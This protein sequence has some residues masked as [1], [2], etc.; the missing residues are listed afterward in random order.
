[1]VEGAGALVGRRLEWDALHD[2]LEGLE[3]KGRVVIE[4]AG[5]QGIGKTRLIT[6]LCAEAERR[7]YLVFSGRAAEFEQG[8][9]FGVFVDALDDYLASVDRTEFDDLGVELDELA[10]V[11]PAL[12]RPT[13]HPPGAVSVE[14]YRAH[15]EMRT[16]LDA[17]SQ[18][19]PVVLTL[20]DLHWADDASIELVSYLLR[21]PPRG[22]VLTVMAFRPAQLAKQFE[23]VLE[24]STRAPSVV[25]LDLHPLTEDEAS[26]L[27]DPDLPAPVRGE[28][29][30]LSGGNPFYLEELVRGVRRGRTDTSA[31]SVGENLA[32]VPPAV[33]RALADELG[34]LSAAAGALIR[35][36]AVVGDPFEVGLAAAAGET[37]DS[38]VFAA[39]DELLAAHLVRPT[40]LPRR[41]QFR[42]PLVRHAVYQTAP[43][44]WR[45]GAHAR[46]A[47]TLD[48]QGA[49]PPARAHHVERS[50]RRG[51]ASAVGLLIEAGDATAARAPAIAARWY[52]AALRL[53]PEAPAER[54]RR[55]NVL[56]ALASAL[57]DTG[58][59]VDSRSALIEALRLVPADDAAKRVDVSTRCAGVEILLGQFAV[60]NRR[61]QQLL[62]ELPE[63]I[64]AEA[65]AAHLMQ[66]IAAEYAMDFNSMRALARD[67]FDIAT[68]CGHRPLTANAAAALAF[69]E[70]QDPST[71]TSMPALRHAAALVDRTTDEE[72]SARL[73]T[74]D[75]IGMA[76]LLAD[77][78]A[79]ALRHIERG[80]DVARTMGQTHH[81][82]LTL[83]LTLGVLFTHLG[84]LDE[85]AE[86]AEA[87]VELA[88]L[89]GAPRLAF[90]SYVECVV[91]TARGDLEDARRAGEES[92][93]LAD[94]LDQRW[95]SGVA[96]F[97][98]AVALLTSGEPER[99]RTT[100]LKAGGGADLPSFGVQQRCHGYEALT[101]AELALGDSTAADRWATC[102]EA[103]AIP[104]FPVSTAATQRARAAVFL[105]T[106]L[107]EAAAQLAL[108]AAAAEDEAFARLAAARSRTLGGRALAKAGRRVEA[109]ELLRRAEADLS[110]CGAVRYADDAARELRRLGGRVT[111]ARRDSQTGDLGL[112]RRELEVAMLVT[113]G[114]TNREIAAVLSLS[115]RTVESHLARVFAKL[116]ISSRA[117]IGRALAGRL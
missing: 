88:R 26:D 96:G 68:S 113:E 57:T 13:E 36:A 72:L 50:A 78:F 44:G 45:I 115:D 38:L 89:E 55:L 58:R 108:T 92:L 77:R 97:S 29:Y 23:G 43:A 73:R 24:R 71:D 103:A 114:K 112:S 12:S 102:G 14:R 49:A 106:G 25:R 109:I 34:A 54:P 86:I 8:D 60:A 47:A 10:S 27:L 107:P 3:T 90:A 5:E 91:S 111:R 79:D 35:G 33:Q 16:L 28:L 100:M 40:Q 93:A 76:E 31:G 6:E 66:A 85:A 51:D 62:V 46:A 69:V 99:S 70:S 2:A 63:P 52:E 7:R 39:L 42:H 53:M 65:A 41:F 17:L 82:V 84:R 21:R 11:F 117:A 18:R 37:P 19:R 87:M 32:A 9:A 48:A 95:I 1:V 59:L 4:L 101:F 94:A 15:Q 81:H 116:G 83:K 30:R 20:D 56:S 74:I 22:R 105:A 98:L 110:E 64:S 104:S 80:L 61:L 75:E 67:A